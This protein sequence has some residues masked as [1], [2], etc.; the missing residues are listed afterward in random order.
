MLFACPQS[1]LYPPTQLI[2]YYYNNS[3]HP[4]PLAEFR[5][6]NSVK[7]DHPPEIFVTMHQIANCPRIFD[8]K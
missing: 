4:T 1:A 7:M 3:I 8:K 2:K 5:S 6:L